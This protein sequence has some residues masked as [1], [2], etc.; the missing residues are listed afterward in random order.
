MSVLKKIGQAL[1]KGAAIAS[2]I[3]GFPFIS[4]LLG[5]IPGKA[6]QDVAVAT[7]DIGAIAKIVSVAEAMFQTSGSGSQKLAAA[8]PIVQQVL[9]TWA[10]SNLPG[11]SKVHDPAKLAAAAQGITSSF[12]DFLNALG[13]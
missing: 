4:S 5:A 2:E 8:S 3:L 1:V 13:D 9:L 12:A 6:G 11:H 7:S 10:E